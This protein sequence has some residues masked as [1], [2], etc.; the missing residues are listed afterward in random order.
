MLNLCPGNRPKD[1]FSVQLI[2]FPVSMA[3]PHHVCA[4]VDTEDGD[5]AQ[6]QGNA[7]NDEEEEGAD[8]WNVT[9]QCVGDRLL[10]V[11]KDQTTCLGLKNNI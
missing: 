8:L 7:G 1:Y 11:I 5:G 9:C 4:Q 6:G 3:G 2:P 10:Q